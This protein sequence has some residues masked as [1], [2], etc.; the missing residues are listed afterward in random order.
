MMSHSLSI[1]PDKTDDG[2]FHQEGGLS[3]LKPPEIFKGK[4]NFSEE[5]KYIGITLDRKLTWNSHLQNRAKRAY[6]AY[7][8]LV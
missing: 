5:V 4:L 6:V 1:N 7:E 2:P 8:W 3:G